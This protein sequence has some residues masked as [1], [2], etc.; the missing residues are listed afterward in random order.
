MDTPIDRCRQRLRFSALFAL[1]AL[2]AFNSVLRAA[3]PPAAT[4]YDKRAARA[5]FNALTPN[6]VP[7]A[8]AIP[9]DLPSKLDRFEKEDDKV[10]YALNFG[11]REGVD[12]R[13]YYKITLNGDLS[14]AEAA[15]WRVLTERDD[16]T[17]AEVF[18]KPV[19]RSEADQFNA[20]GVRRKIGNV[21][22]TISQRRPITEDPKAGAAELLK[23]FA[24]LLQ[25]A[26]VNRLFARLVVGLPTSD[27]I[28]ELNL[29]RPLPFSIRSD[30]EP[31]ELQLRA[32]IESADGSILGVVE[33]FTFQLRGPLAKFV[34][35]EGATL[36]AAGYY[37]VRGV[38]V[39]EV[40]LRFDPQNGALQDA[41][42]R[43]VATR[44]ADTGAGVRLRVGAK[45]AE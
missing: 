35:V 28:K 2:L 33:R 16:A 39:A 40:T 3:D 21:V 32:Q 18:W 20:V 36:N 23:R 11:T 12:D 24:T 5:L 30:N 8:D 34:T 15:D 26:K 7:D 37:E 45:L 19:K 41:A 25:Q 14:D 29:A 13:G 9:A 10:T 6:A 31:T 4:D 38:D 22:L 1:A 44:T 17:G 43:H 27:G 42:V